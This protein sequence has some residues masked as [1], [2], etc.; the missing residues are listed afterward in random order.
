MTT[1]ATLIE[2]QFEVLK[3]AQAAARAA[4]SLSDDQRDDWAN[5]LTELLQRAR[6]GEDLARIKTLTTTI[7]DA[8]ANET[9]ACSAQLVSQVE[10]AIEALRTR[11]PAVDDAAFDAAVAPL[12]SLTTPDR[13]GH[14]AG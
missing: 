13:P 3:A 10:A 14:L 2:E 12:N 9:E 4:R 1:V 5:E 8:T 6:Y 7:E 11:Y